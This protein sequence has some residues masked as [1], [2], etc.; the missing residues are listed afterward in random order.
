MQLPGVWEVVQQE[1]ICA[2][3]LTVTLTGLTGDR[4]TKGRPAGFFL[5]LCAAPSPSSE[6]AKGVKTVHFCGWIQDG[7]DCQEGWGLRGRPCKVCLFKLLAFLGGLS[8]SQE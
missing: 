7:R 3:H 1:G 8:S 4:V 5:K 2:S 6:G